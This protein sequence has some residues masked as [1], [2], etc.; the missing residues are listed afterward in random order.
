MIKFLTD[1][2]QLGSIQNIFKTHFFSANESHPT[3][4]Y[5]FKVS[6]GNTKTMCE[7]YSKLT[8]KHQTDVNGNTITVCEICSGVF[9]VHFEQISQIVLVFPL[10]NL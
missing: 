7:I 1:I 2:P 6:D 5:L 8:K 3:D 4:I 9:I 10:L